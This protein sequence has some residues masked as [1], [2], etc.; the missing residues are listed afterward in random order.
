MPLM[1]LR[2]FVLGYLGAAVAATVAA[3]AELS[4]VAIRDDETV[5]TLSGDI[6]AGDA[7]ATEALIKTINDD[8]R[9]VSAIRLDSPGGGV[10]EAVKLAELIRRAKVPMVVAAGSRCASACFIVF[11]AGVEKFA[12]YDAAIG[13][14]G[15]SDRFG[16]QTAQAEAATVSMARIASELGVPPRIVGRI[17]ATRPSDIAWLSPEDLR[18]MGVIMTGRPGQNALSASTGDLAPANTGRSWRLMHRT[19]PLNSAARPPP[20]ER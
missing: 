8:G 2:R 17:I 11:A 15:V 1:R 18:A 12:N 14:H 19:D 16:H 3:A 4:S 6:E 5:I 9:L 13:V 20:A 7:D 10:A